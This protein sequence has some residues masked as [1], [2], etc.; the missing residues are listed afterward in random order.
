MMMLTVVL[1]LTLRGD[2]RRDGGPLLVPSS[3]FVTE[4]I[5]TM[6]SEGWERSIDG[7]WPRV[8]VLRIE[9]LLCVTV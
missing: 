5:G 7:R 4:P 6:R 1:K 9:M 2:G 8:A 3:F